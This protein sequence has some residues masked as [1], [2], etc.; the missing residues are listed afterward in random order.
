MLRYL[1]AMAWLRWRVMLNSAKPSKKRDVMEQLSRLGAVLAPAIMAVA[2]IPSTILIAILGFYAGLSMARDPFYVSIVTTIARV[3]VALSF[4]GVL[5]A[6]LVRTIQGAHIGLPRL[7]LLPIPRRALHLTEFLAGL[8]DPWVAVFVPGILLLPVGLLAGG[9]LVPAAIAAVASVL[10]LAALAGVGSLCSFTAMLVFRSR[11]R[12]ELVTLVLFLVL[13]LIGFVPLIVEKAIDRNGDGRVI[14]VDAGAEE[15]DGANAPEPEPAEPGV[16]EP[17]EEQRRN[18]ENAISRVEHMFVWLRWFPS[19]LYGVSIARGSTGLTGSSLLHVLGL[20]LFCGM[21]YTL[22]SRV[23]GRLIETPEGGSGGA[24]DHS[25]DLRTPTLPWASH[26][27]SAMAFAVFRTSLRTVRGKMAVYFTPAAVALMWVILGRE[28]SE[29]F[30]NVA[31]GPFLFLFGALLSFVSLQPV[32]HNQFAVD[33][34]GMT[35]QLLVPA[36]ERQIAA[37]KVFGNGLLG[38]V[39][40][41]LC[42]VMALVLTRDGHPFYWLAMLLASAAGFVVL[43]PICTLLSAAL[44]KSADLSR[45]GKAGN[46]HP[47]AGLLGVLLTPLTLLPPVGLYLIGM[48]LDSPGLSFVLTAGWCALAVVIAL[49]LVRAAGA[50]VSRRRE[51]LLLVASGR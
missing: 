18:L 34:A 42:L 16:E 10:V 3:V 1:R 30:E 47:I 12:A 39:P 13:S 32:L 48:L 7:I 49:P 14:V 31:L 26:G 2:L 41:A 9:A 6:P 36:T 50:L 27:T 22:S 20:T 28:V 38:V 35:L 21:L 40:T 11:R 17:R 51:N 44:P 33:G 24:A 25:T 23:Y 45:M 8:T 15:P 46:P 29:N 37:G 4:F 19:E 5:L 43:A